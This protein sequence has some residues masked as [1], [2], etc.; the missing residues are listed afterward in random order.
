MWNNHAMVLDISKRP[1]AINHL[2]RHSLNSS[3][4]QVSHAQARHLPKARTGIDG[5]Q[6][7]DGDGV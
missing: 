7:E 1:R 3:Y 4:I 5:A 6:G 2:R